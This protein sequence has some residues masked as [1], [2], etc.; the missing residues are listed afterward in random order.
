MEM[1]WK[2]GQKDEYVRNM[3][4]CWQSGGLTLSLTYEIDDS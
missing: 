1:K 4:A 2:Q 3:Y